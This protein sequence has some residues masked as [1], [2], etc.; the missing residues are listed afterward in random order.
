MELI[1]ALFVGL[2]AGFLAR[3]LVPGKDPMG[4]LGTLAL[5]LAGSFLGGFLARVILND[6]EINIFGS[7]IGAVLVLLVWR[8]IKGRQENKPAV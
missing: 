7:T 6:N 4:L 5:G 1:G 8:A 2:I 3:F